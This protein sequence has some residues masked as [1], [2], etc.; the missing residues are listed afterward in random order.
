VDAVALTRTSH[1]L[2]LGD[3]YVAKAENPN[4]IG[5]PPMGTVTQD[6]TFNLED[7]VVVRQ[8]LSVA[9]Q[10]PYRLETTIYYTEDDSQH[11]LKVVSNGKVALLGLEQ[12]AR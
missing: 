3:R 7:A 5:L 4:P 9:D 2:Y 12:A 6:V 10:A 8:L 1:R 11:Q